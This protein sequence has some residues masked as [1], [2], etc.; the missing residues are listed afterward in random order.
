MD[1]ISVKRIAW[2]D[3]MKGILFCL[4]IMWHIAQR[5]N[6][7]TP[8]ILIEIIEFFSPFRMPAYFFLSGL[9]FSNRRLRTYPLYV[10][11]KTKTL[12]LPYISFSFLFLFLDWNLYLED[13]YWGASMKKIF[14]EALSSSKSEPLWFVFTLYLICIIYYPFHRWIERNKFYYIVLSGVFI[15]LSYIIT[16][17]GIYLPFNLGTAIS[18]M[19]FFVWGVCSKELIL[20]ITTISF[21]PKV[22]LIGAFLSVYTLLYFTYNIGGY[23][24]G[25]HIENYFM[26]YF[27]AILG[28]IWLCCVCSELAK[29]PGKIMGIFEN[30]ARN[31][32]VILGT[33]MYILFIEVY[34]VN[35]M[36]DL[37]RY[38]AFIAVFVIL[39]LS[40]IIC[41]G[42]FN[43]YFYFLMGKKKLSFKESLSISRE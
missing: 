30:I 11:S 12:L 3:I 13:G 27:L 2:I 28:I 24:F 25:N 43:K 9:L 40:E 35:K 38:I 14:I 18:A 7:Y 31:A 37:N 5:K 21:L 8:D 6:L 42:L 1:N 16:Y 19:P 10:Q 15:L 23:L 29:L 22:L 20:K 32:L 26:F 17:T 4:V 33:H 39:V 41:I 34:I 36:D